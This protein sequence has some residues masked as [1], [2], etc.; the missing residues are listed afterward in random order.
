MLT[1]VKLYNSFSFGDSEPCLRS[2]TNLK[3]VCVGGG[4]YI[5]PFWMQVEWAFALQQVLIMSSVCYIVA[6]QIDCKL[7]H[8][9]SV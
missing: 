1:T 3:C 4:G 9:Q 7:K 8:A 5:S 2:H 6:L